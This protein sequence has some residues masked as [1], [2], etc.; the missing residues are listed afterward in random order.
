LMKNAAK[1]GLPSVTPPPVCF[2]DVANRIR[3]V[4]AEIQK[5]DS[6]ER[7]NKLG[8]EILF[9]SPEFSDEHTLVCDNR[10]ITSRKFLIA[11]GSKAA[12][13]DIEGLDAVNYLTNRE[14]FYLDTLP[15]SLIVLG[16]GPIAMEMAQAFNRLGSKVTVIQRSDQVL[17]KEDRDLADIVMQSMEGEGVRFH[18]G[19]KVVKVEGSE[20]RKKVSIKQAQQDTIVVEGT[21]ILVALGRSVNTEGLGLDKIGLN[22]NRGGVS[23]DGKMR[24]N[25]KHIFAAGDVIGG[26]QF[27]HAAGYEAGIV[28][29]NAIFNIPRKVN[30]TW[31]PWCTYTGPEL[32]S[33][34]MNEKAAKAAGLE[35]RLWSEDFNSSDRAL[36]EEESTGRIKLLLNK[37]GKP[38]GVQILGLHGGEL[39][40]EWVAVLNG[41]VKLSTL[42]GAV[43]PYP[44]LAEMNKRVVGSI[45]SEKLFSEKVRGILRF[46]FK[47]QGKY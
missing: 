30:Y 14:I 13:P 22:Y 20:G 39:L 2:E 10:K 15:K 35:Y 31:M 41:K 8:A 45:F 36:A 17:S 21:D 3:R 25:H 1:F 32:A 33:I 40:A 46:L 19:C 5:H 4:V 12:I 29:S 27:T 6:V 38:L 9:G 34:G 47:Y 23:V 7:F 28:V 11:T 37:K 42:A 24:T 16:A 44:T 26:Y 43:H 18:L